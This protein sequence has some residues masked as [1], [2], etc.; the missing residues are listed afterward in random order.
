MK[1]KA[2]TRNEW[3]MAA[4]QTHNEIIKKTLPT[5]LNWFVNLITVWCTK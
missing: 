4:N 3:K 2:D 5:A 1:R